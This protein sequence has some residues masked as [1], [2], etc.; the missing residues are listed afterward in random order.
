[1]GGCL[2]ISRILLICLFVSAGTCSP[3]H[4]LETALVYLPISQS[5]RSNSLYVLRYNIWQVIA[6]SW[7][8]HPKFTIAITAAP[9][10]INCVYRSWNWIESKLNWH[11]EYYQERGLEHNTLHSTS[12]ETSAVHLYSTT[13]FQGSSDARCDRNRNSADKCSH[14]VREYKDCCLMGCDVVKSCTCLLTFRKNLLHI[15][16]GLNTKPS[17]NQTVWSSTLMI[18]G[19]QR[20]QQLDNVE[21]IDDEW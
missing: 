21:W 15:S 19:Q 11:K 16:S 1:M 7:D 8:L 9:P 13:E 6:T 17:K 2:A 4:R 20:F 18:Y 10:Q 14:W 12:P 5:L 3:S